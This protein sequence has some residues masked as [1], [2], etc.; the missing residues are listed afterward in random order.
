MDDPPP[1]KALPTLLLT[2]LL[3]KRVWTILSSTEERSPGPP[4]PSRLLTGL[5][6][7]WKRLLKWRLTW[8]GG[9]GGGRM[10]SLDEFCF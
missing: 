10:L 9:G 5:G 7:T 4:E 6:F 2:L 8:G 3:L 1:R